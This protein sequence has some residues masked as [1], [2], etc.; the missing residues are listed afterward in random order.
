MLKILGSILKGIFHKKKLII[1]SIL[2]IISTVTFTYILLTN[3]D[4]IYR[5]KASFGKYEPVGF[6]DLINGNGEAVGWAVDM[7]VPSQS[8]DVEFY[9][10]PNMIG[11]PIGSTKAN[12]FRVDVDTALK[13][14]GNHGYRFK[15]PNNL[16]NGQ[17]NTIYAFAVDIQGG[18]KLLQP[19][20]GLSF[21]LGS[22]G[23]KNSNVDG[24]VDNARENPNG[25]FTVSGWAKDPDSDNPLNVEI[26]VDDV[27]F[28]S[29][30]ANVY[31]A[32]GNIGNHAFS[33]THATLGNGQ[34]KIQIFAKDINSRGN[35]TLLRNELKGSPKTLTFTCAGLKGNAW[36]WCANPD[37]SEYWVNRQADTVYLFNKDI[38]VGIDKSFGG[39]IF[40]LYN[41]TRKKNLIEENGG[42]AIQL[43]IY[44]RDRDGLYKNYKGCNTFKTDYPVEG[45]TAPWNPIQAISGLCGWTGSGNDAKI[46]D[47]Q[48]NSVTMVI[49]NPK[50]FSKNT[51]G[52]QALT[53]TQKVTLEDTYIKVDYNVKFDG[54]PNGNII[55]TNQ[56]EQEIPAIFTSPGINH[57]FYWNGARGVNDPDGIAK[58]ILI[59]RPA[60]VFD[61]KDLNFRRRPNIKEGFYDSTIK[62]NE[63]WWGVCDESEKNCVTVATLDNNLRGAVMQNLAQVTNPTDNTTNPFANAD[64]KGAY[65]TALATWPTMDKGFN[66]NFTIYIFPY[67]WDK[68][69]SDKTIR[70]RIINLSTQ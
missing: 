12:L 8:I 40:Q 51:W 55:N 53:Y 47:Q 65:I 33:F 1:Y 66:K 63:K 44:G 62:P 20:G 70:D 41:D 37:V 23:K 14:T 4:L 69:I 56:D 6:I 29:F 7:D 24:W 54:W 59:G 16:R 2:L 10:N 61:I 50:N 35:E 27:P 39:T 42:S 52:F 38:K 19:A 45:T 26:F 22:G 60:L 21:T 5:S 48:F 31:R 64:T 15:I 32:D 13:I 67:K 43:S 3:P 68:K 46:T 57:F 58:Q 18:K 30:I 17:Q 9:L 34:H 36:E 11:S 49:N 25:T 28:D